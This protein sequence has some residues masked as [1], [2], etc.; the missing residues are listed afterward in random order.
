MAKE[1]IRFKIDKSEKKQVEVKR[2]N[3][4]TGEEEI[5]LQN[6]TVKTPVEF[7]MKAPTRR[8]QDEAELFYSVELSRAVKK[9]VLTKAMLIKKYAD[10][11]GT[12]T[13]E[14]S[15][16]LL[17]KLSRSNELVNEIQFL[18]SEDKEKNKEEI[19]NKSNELLRI[20][21]EMLEMESALQGV[22]QHTADSKAEKALLFWYILHLFK[23]IEE[24]KEKEI[25][26]G[27]DYEEKLEN[28]YTLEESE[29]EFNQEVVNKLMRATTYW[30]YNGS[31]DK[32][33]FLKF[34]ENEE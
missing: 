28:F 5:V 20:R 19:E 13:E 2:K 9:G 25:F 23:Q 11:G 1:I 31:K 21:K 32:E 7:V 12:L 18:T 3:K 10:T 27:L 22:Y 17:R 30:M 34:I 16:E 15:K 14:E 6:K 29:D 4:E 26:V 24:D 8:Q 33:N